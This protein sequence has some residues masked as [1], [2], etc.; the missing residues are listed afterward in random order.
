MS[1]MDNMLINACK[2]GQKG[3]AQTLLSNGDVDVNKRDAMGF[4]ALHYACQKGARDLVSLLLASGADASACSNDSTTPLHMCSRSGNKDVIRMLLDAGADVNATDRNGRTPIMGMAS[5]GK[6][7]AAKMLLENGADPTMADN[8][9]HTVMD[10]ATSKGLKGLVSALADAEGSADAKDSVGNTPLHQACCDRER[11]GCQ[12]PQRRRREPV[13][14]GRPQR[15]AEHSR[16][17]PGF[18]CRPIGQSQLGRP[19][20]PHRGS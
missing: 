8:D 6:T 14:P 20:P 2:N 5:E 9:G 10:I 1:Q 7:D 12:R 11:G 16:D 13:V 15:G 3:V 17:P 19:S 4:T 18:W